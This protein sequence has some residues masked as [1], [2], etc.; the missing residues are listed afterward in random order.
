MRISGD[1][2]I[3]DRSSAC[4]HV[5]SAIDSHTNE[6]S[7]SS[8]TRSRGSSSN[9][10]SRSRRTSD[11][12]NRGT[13][14]EM[15]DRRARTDSQVQQKRSLPHLYKRLLSREGTDLMWYNVICKCENA[16]YLYTVTILLFIIM[17]FRQYLVNHLNY[18]HIIICISVQ[19]HNH[20]YCKSNIYKI[21]VNKHVHDSYTLILYCILYS[22]I[23]SVHKH[24]HTLI[25]WLAGTWRYY[26]TVQVLYIK[27]LDIQKTQCTK[28]TEQKYNKIQYVV[29]SHKQNISTTM[30]MIMRKST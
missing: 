9:T 4:A 14:T 22:I 12:S 23:Y 25:V 27:E 18:V 20:T 16:D 13:N 2:N 8:N 1:I 5:D 26:S 24:N 10:R 29:C 3:M 28:D 11:R 7:S 6:I 21:V 17:Y 15:P 19:V 30:K